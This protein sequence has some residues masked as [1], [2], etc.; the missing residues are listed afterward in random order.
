MG[1]TWWQPQ[2]LVGTRTYFSCWGRRCDLLMRGAASI[3][4]PT[5]PFSWLA[6]LGWGGGT[7]RAPVLSERAAVPHHSWARPPLA[8]HCC[9]HFIARGKSLSPSV[10]VWAQRPLLELSIWKGPLVAT[11][12][13]GEV[14]KGRAS[15]PEQQEGP[16]LLGGRQG[17]KKRNKRCPEREHESRLPC[18]P[19]PAEKQPRRQPPTEEVCTPPT[20]LIDATQ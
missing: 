12:Q 8:E 2:A 13:E 4:L 18:S 3:K 19:T 14:R 20:S 1:T 17:S 9:P 16:A 11:G 10:S 5:G 6:P 15:V 7:P